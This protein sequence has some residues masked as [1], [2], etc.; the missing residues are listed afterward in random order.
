MAVVNKQ[1]LSDAEK[2]FYGIK[3]RPVLTDR[4]ALEALPDEAFDALV[5]LLSQDV[6]SPNKWVAMY[7]VVMNRLRA[8]ARPYLHEQDEDV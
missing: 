2:A 4:Q 5:D 7:A 6:D 8:R 1:A 3:S